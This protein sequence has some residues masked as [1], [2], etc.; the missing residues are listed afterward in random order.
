[1]EAQLCYLHRRVA[2]LM[3]EFDNERASEELRR[4]KSTLPEVKIQINIDIRQSK[5]TCWSELID[6][7]DKDPFGKPYKM[8]MRKL[9][10]PL[11]L[12]HW[13]NGHCTESSTP[14]SRLGSPP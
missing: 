10:G 9:R 6:S 3:I 7:V 4:G 5:E 1:M 12:S 13:K 11:Q 8:V 2:E 14:F